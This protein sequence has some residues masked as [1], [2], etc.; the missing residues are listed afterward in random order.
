MAKGAAITGIL[1]L[2]GEAGRSVADLEQIIVAGSFGY[3]LNPESLKTIGL[4][5]PE[6]TGRITFVGNSS[7]SGASLPVLNR[8]I[9]RDMEYLASIIKVFDLGSHPDFGKKFISQLRFPS[10]VPAAKDR[11]IDL[12]MCRIAPT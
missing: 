7:L 6:Y 2:L 10:A 8:D 12:R 9:L 5:P 1:A 4:L 11:L 3:H